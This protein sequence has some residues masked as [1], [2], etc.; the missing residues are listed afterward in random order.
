[1]EES[2]FR[3]ICGII[4]VTEHAKMTSTM[5]YASLMRR[6]CVAQAIAKKEKEKM[7]ASISCAVPIGYG[8]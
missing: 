2:L 8:G 3:L 1:M 7:P 6:D 5:L 4:E